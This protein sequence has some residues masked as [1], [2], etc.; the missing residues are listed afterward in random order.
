[1]KLTL[2][3]G[4]TSIL[5]GAQQESRRNLIICPGSKITCLK[6]R[7]NFHDPGGSTRELPALQRVC[8]S[9]DIYHAEELSAVQLALPSLKII[10]SLGVVK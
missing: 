2:E 1:M 10:H 8:S 6:H 9:R 5:R 3:F 4:V 7:L